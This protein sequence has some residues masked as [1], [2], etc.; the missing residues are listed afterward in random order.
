MDYNPE[1]LEGIKNDLEKEEGIEVVG[2]L[3]DGVNA[4]ETI[5]KLENIDVLIIN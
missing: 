5:D 2:C 3:S 1:F 4:L